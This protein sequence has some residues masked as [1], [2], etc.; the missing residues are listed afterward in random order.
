MNKIFKKRV[1]VLEQSAGLTDSE[2]TIE[3]VIVNP[4]KTILGRYIE[5]EFI[6]EADYKSQFDN[7]SEYEADLKE[8]AKIYYLS[9]HE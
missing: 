3:R 9:L 4:D 7:V 6:A 2:I 1:D 8:I 5:G